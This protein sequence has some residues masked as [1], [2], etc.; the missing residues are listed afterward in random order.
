[1][2]NII[3]R[4]A[5]GFM[6][7]GV[8]MSTVIMPI[9]DQGAEQ[10]RAREVMSARVNAGILKVRAKKGTCSATLKVLRRNDRV[11]VLSTGT[12]WV[13]VQSG[14]VVGYTQ[15]KLLTTGYGGTAADEG[16][17]S[18]GQQVA[19]FALKFVGNPYR[20]GGTSLTG[21]TD[22]SGFVMSVYRHFGKKL[23]RTSSSQR[24]A[25]RGV[26]SLSAAKPG[27]IICYSGHVAIYLG[28]RKI[29]HASSRKTGIK[30]T[31]NAAYRHIVAIR[32]VF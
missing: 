16:G 18:K 23:P 2:L 21:G 32:R 31:N 9:A 10:V 15:G 5:A 25:G 19:N 12:R 29:V 14:K 1:M 28:N 13:K 3:K 20:Y 11:K 8:L 17:Y 4:I 24:R 7:S 22:C 30:V 27:D 6:V 26:G